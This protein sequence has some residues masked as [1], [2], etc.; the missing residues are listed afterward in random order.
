MGP[1]KQNHRMSR[2]QHY[3]PGLSCNITSPESDRYNCIAWAAE[4]FQQWWEPDILNI[5][6]WP[7]S[8]PR[9]MTLDAYIK[10]FES[11]GYII[12]QDGKYEEGLSKIA[13]FVDAKGIPTHA[14][15]LLPS[16]RWT[17]KC[18]TLEDIEHELNALCG[19]LYGHVHCY[20][21]KPA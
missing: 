10:A 5:Y 19:Q 4:D 3:F 2:L 17:S 11:V 7:P 21:K 14:A 8:V 6:Y 13:L 1:Q 18:G 20:M 16:A 12:C 15:R 9:L